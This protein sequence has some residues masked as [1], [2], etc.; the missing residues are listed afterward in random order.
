MSLLTIGQV[1]KKTNVNIETI[2]YYESLGVLPKPH[3]NP[4]SGYRQYKEN[5]IE[6]LNFIL[7]AKELGFSL[8][9]I[10]QLFALRIKSNTTCGDIKTRAE[11]KIKEIEEKIKTLQRMKKALNKLSSQCKGKGPVGDCPIIDAFSVS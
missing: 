7:N 9:E 11:N 1:A 3:R 8:K 10:K 6:R 2:R 4:N 5:T